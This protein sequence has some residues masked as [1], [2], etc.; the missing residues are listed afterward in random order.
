MIELIAAAAGCFALGWVCRGIGELSPTRPSIKPWPVSSGGPVSLKSRRSEPD[1]PEQFVPME[2]GRIPVASNSARW[3]IN[4]PVQMA[5]CGGPCWESRDP[6]QCDCGALW[7]DVPKGSSPSTP[8]TPAK[9]SGR[10]VT[11]ANYWGGYY[12]PRTP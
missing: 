6:N 12:P 4:S 7:V 8:I 10:P 2:E 1:P 11:K 9:P 5:E 3:F